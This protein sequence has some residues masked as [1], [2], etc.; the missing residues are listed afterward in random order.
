MGDTGRE[1]PVG[2]AASRA[3]TDAELNAIMQR[4]DDGLSQGA[5]AVGV[6]IQETPAARPWEIVEMFRV[7]AR[8][9]AAVHVHLRS[10]AAPLYFLETEEVLGAAAAAGGRRWRTRSR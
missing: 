4:I 10:V 6:L 9:R 1:A 8:H 5:V 7:A 2:P 3:A